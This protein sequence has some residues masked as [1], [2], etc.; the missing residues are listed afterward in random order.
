M[1]VLMDTVILDILLFHFH[2]A[3]YILMLEIYITVLASGIFFI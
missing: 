1:L 3:E 2:V